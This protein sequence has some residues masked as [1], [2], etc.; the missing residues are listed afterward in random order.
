MAESDR[1]AGCGR[2]AVVLLVVAIAIVTLGSRACP[3]PPVAHESLEEML[4]AAQF[5]VDAEM[6]YAWTV[7]SLDGAELNLE[8]LRGKTVFLNLWA[9]WCPPCQA[10]MPSIQRLYHA[11]REMGVEFVLISNEDPALVADYAEGEGLSM[12]FYTT[13]EQT[14]PAFQRYGIP[15]TFIISPQGRIVLKWL[16]SYEWDSPKAIAFLKRVNSI[17]STTAPEETEPGPP[18]PPA[19]AGDE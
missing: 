16:G 14:P 13:T 9:S 18:D 19:P 3:G 11:T 6:D 5:A 1:Y 2:G 8:T 7:R 4:T 10:E 12:P 15:M 17:P